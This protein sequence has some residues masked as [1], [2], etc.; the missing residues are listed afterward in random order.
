V[1]YGIAGQLNRFETL[2]QSAPEAK[3]GDIEMVIALIDSGVTDVPG[4][5][6]SQP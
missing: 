1:F 2:R 4:P 6:A 5:H 3:Q